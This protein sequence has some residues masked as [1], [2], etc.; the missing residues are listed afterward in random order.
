MENA[1][2]N[3]YRAFDDAAVRSL[4]P[5][6]RV[7][8]AVRSAMIA[9]ERREFDM[10]QRIGLG[11]SDV[12]VMPVFHRPSGTSATKILS[13]DAGRTLFI[14]GA[15]V[16]TAAGDPKTLVADAGE[17]TKLRTGALSGVAADLLC[18][19]GAETMTIFGA[20][21]Q[22]Y[23][24]VMA[25][26]AVRRLRRLAIV[27]RTAARA[28]ALAHRL[29]RD[30]PGV[31][32]ST[33]S[34]ANGGLLKESDIVCCVTT[35]QRPLFEI[36]DLAPEACVLAVGSYRPDMREVPAE[37]LHTSGHIVVDDV[38]ACTAESGDVIEALRAGH[39]SEDDLLPLG[40]ALQDSPR[41]SGRRLFKTVGV[42]VQ[43]WAVM[44]VLR[45]ADARYAGHVQT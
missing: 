27:N 40:R 12:L 18:V 10:P 23:D 21:G 29:E 13:L 3:S 22:A 20:G 26:A 42:A 15:V 30:L 44:A 24:Q 19:A 32:I 43:D 36:D 37:L 11:G 8:N 31:M 45:D 2:T 38:R 34:S 6:T 17:V 5:M 25:V 39:L 41:L 14:T 7:I 33:S 9:L 35:A 28:E 1:V 16:S 4:A